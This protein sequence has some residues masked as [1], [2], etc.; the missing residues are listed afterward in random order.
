MV[1]LRDLIY[2]EVGKVLTTFS[3]PL[4]ATLIQCIWEG[5]CGLVKSLDDIKKSPQPYISAWMRG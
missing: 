4:G 5:D 1:G 2:S 3:L